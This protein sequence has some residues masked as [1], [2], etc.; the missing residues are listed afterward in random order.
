M[1][2]PVDKAEF[3]IKEYE[4][5][6]GMIRDYVEYINNLQYYYLGGC[7]AVYAFCVQQKLDGVYSALYFLP[8]L[9]TLFAYIT[10]ESFRREIYDIRT[11]LR[12][13][14]G[15]IELSLEGFD[16]FYHNK[17]SEGNHS[18]MRQ[19]RCW[20]WILASV[21]NTIFPLVVITSQ[22]CS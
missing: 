5:L 9:F 6:R 16:V 1:E 11:Y 2:T 4:I 7:A 22:R 19:S 3:Y 10:Y 14:E 20:F 18:L 12:K 8:L 21:V 15:M 13:M 17:Y